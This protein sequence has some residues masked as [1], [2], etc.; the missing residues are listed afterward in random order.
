MSSSRDPGG[1]GRRTTHDRGSGPR[2]GRIVLVVGGALVAVAVLIWGVAAGVGAIMGLLAPDAPVAQSKPAPKVASQVATNTPT[3]TA[4]ATASVSAD[5]SASAEASASSVATN[6]IAAAAV[7]FP[8]AP[9]VEPRTISHLSPSEKM[10]A[11]TLDDGGNYDERLLTLFEDND[12]HLTTFLLGSFVKNNPKFTERLVKD[13][14]EIA[15]HTWD[16]G[17]LA[18]MDSSEIKTELTRAQK[19]I[20]A[21]TGNQAPYMRPPGGATDSTVKQTSAK[22]GYTVILWNKSFADTSKVAT[23]DRLYHNVVDGAKSGDI[24]LCHW[25]GKATYDGMKLIIPELKRR[26]FKIVSISEMLA[27]SKGN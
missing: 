13:G 24:V 20:S 21:H 6:A 26:G 5:A 23:G 17:D 7:P 3:G 18:R 12:L 22:L 27:A 11:I 14:F 10:I 8:D 19:A 25:G 9:S 15:N 16:H 4:D 1:S 2:W